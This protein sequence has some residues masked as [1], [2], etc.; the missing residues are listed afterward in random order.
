MPA[1]KVEFRLGKFISNIKLIFSLTQVLAGVNCDDHIVL[2][3]V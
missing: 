1:L 3:T 2:V